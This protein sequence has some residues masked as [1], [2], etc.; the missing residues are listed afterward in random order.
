MGRE[1]VTKN[2][3]QSD[4]AIGDGKKAIGKEPACGHG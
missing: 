1:C 2:I 3:K 4:M